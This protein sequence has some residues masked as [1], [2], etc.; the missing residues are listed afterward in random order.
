MGNK[1]QEGLTLVT[2]ASPPAGCLWHRCTYQV[3]VCRKEQRV[4][5]FFTIQSCLF[6]SNKHS[7]YK[8]PQ[9]TG[10]KVKKLPPPVLHHQYSKHCD[11]ASRSG[12]QTSIPTWKEAEM[13]S[14]PNWLSANLSRGLS[15]L[16]FGAVRWNRVLVWS[17]LDD[18]KHMKTSNTKAKE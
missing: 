10:K 15:G 5:C 8:S 2:Q 4:P 18:P 7:C 16:Q 6:P 17:A 12:Q 3:D 13:N 14:T 1:P 11:T 9:A